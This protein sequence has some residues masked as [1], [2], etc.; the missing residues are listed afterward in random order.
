MEV[1]VGLIDKLLK[2][3]TEVVQQVDPPPFQEAKKNPEPEVVPVKKRT[4]WIDELTDPDSPVHEKL[5]KLPETQK[6]KT[7]PVQ[8]VDPIYSFEYSDN[9][10]YIY[11]NG[12]DFFDGE[13]VIAQ[14]DYIL[15]EGFRGDSE[16]LAFFTLK[17]LI[18]IRKFE[19]GV[20]GATI[21]SSGVA[22]VFSD[23]EKVIIMSE[24]GTSVKKFDYGSAPDEARVLADSVCAFVEDD[25]DFVMLKCFVF[26]SQSIWT[27]KIKYTQGE[28]VSNFS[29]DPSLRL[30]GDILEVS[31]PDG[32]FARFSLE[33]GVL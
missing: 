8:K 18:S 24:D 6:K 22:F 11:K 29:T 9:T 12:K 30:V 7:E 1:I 28:N 4:S 5:K 17:K 19:D 2:K 10:F 3:K 31:L 13:A 20:E 21:L 26:A 16:S 33:G 14:G 25:V 27:K 23:N 15:A 32:S